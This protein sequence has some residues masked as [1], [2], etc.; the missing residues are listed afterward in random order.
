MWQMH[1]RE[2]LGK[3]PWNSPFD[4]SM[5]FHFYH[6]LSLFFSLLFL[7]VQCTI[8]KD[9]NISNFTLPSHDEDTDDSETRRREGVYRDDFSFMC[10]Y[11]FLCHHHWLI[12]GIYTHWK[13]QSRNGYKENKAKK[14]SKITEKLLYILCRVAAFSLFLLQYFH[15]CLFYI[16]IVSRAFHNWF[17]IHISTIWIL[18]LPQIWFVTTMIYHYY[19]KHLSA[20][21]LHD[22]FKIITKSIAISCLP[23]LYK[24][25][26]IFPLLVVTYVSLSKL[27]DIIW[28][29]Y[30]F[31]W[32]VNKEPHWVLA[33]TTAYNEFRPNLLFLLIT[34]VRVIGEYWV[35][36][37][38]SPLTNVI[39]TMGHTGKKSR[40]Y[41]SSIILLKAGLL[42][43]T[44]IEREFLS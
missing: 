6:H 32:T 39:I 37:S 1:E 4:F 21:R 24:R 11:P 23:S 42:L 17:S 30:Q 38:R 10:V 28:M 26:S 27:D 44:I 41:G 15:L 34:F 14:Y 2:F 9:K 3:W 31:L 12:T 5:K 8:C 16:I 20:T 13:Q 22:G 18:S 19:G 7:I 35:T 36:Y 43:S 33:H 25:K 40:R 29:F